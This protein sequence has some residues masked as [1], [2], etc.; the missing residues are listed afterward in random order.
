M[1]RKNSIEKN[2]KIKFRV[3]FIKTVDRRSSFTSKNILKTAALLVSGA[4]KEQ[5]SPKK[6]MSLESVSS[7]KHGA[8][9]DTIAKKIELE[10][11]KVSVS[12]AV[13]PAFTETLNKNPQ[14]LKTPKMD[15]KTLKVAT[16]N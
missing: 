13:L 7:I 4:L 15:F 16:T 1:I 8:R 9:F 12:C 11:Q 5:K 6:I 14:A 2:K 3:E 10:L